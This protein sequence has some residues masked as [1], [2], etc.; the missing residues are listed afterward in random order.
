[1]ESEVKAV[2]RRACGGW[3]THEGAWLNDATATWLFFL[4]HLNPYLSVDTKKYGLLQSMGFGRAHPRAIFLGHITLYY[5]LND[6]ILSKYNN[7]EAKS[8]R[9]RMLLKDWLHVSRFLQAYLMTE[10]CK[11]GLRFSCTGIIEICHIPSPR[12]FFIV[13]SCRHSRTEFLPIF[14]CLLAVT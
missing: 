3:S 14:G 12:W 9:N 11:N 13:S 5:V 10:A 8:R 2:V 7:Y 1:M 4:S 6:Y